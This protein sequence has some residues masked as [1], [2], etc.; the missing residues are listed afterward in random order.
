VVAGAGVHVYVATASPA[1]ILTLNTADGSI[2]IYGSIPNVAPCIPV[3]RTT[4]CDASIIDRE[5]RP[6]ALA[7]DQRG[8][9][10][11]ADA[12]QGAIWLIP[13]SGGAARQWL[14][15][16]SFGR[17]D[18]PSGPTGIAIDGAGDVVF[19]IP[20]TLTADA[21]V[22]Y[23]QSRTA[24]GRPGPRTTLATL[25][26]G[27]HPS[28]LVLSAGGTI[29]TCLPDSSHVLELG[30]DGKE[31]R[32]IEIDASLGA[33]LLAGLAFHNESLLAA[34]RSVAGA[35]TAIVR[36]PVGETRGVIGTGPT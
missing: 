32:R 31:L 23:L 11:V 12:G 5:P 26:A 36:V 14:V 10:L 24:D 8:D 4:N 20:A 18:R 34:G 1:Q 29:F 13:A 21:G 15:D 6:S 33:G 35:P 16:P 19:A 7:F 3:A 27:A 28:S 2:Q 30:T 9:L 25:E 22:V 17:A